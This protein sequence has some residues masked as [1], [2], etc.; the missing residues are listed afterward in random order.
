MVKMLNDGDCQRSAMALIMQPS[1]KFLSAAHHT[2]HLILAAN[3]CNG[4][5]GGGGGSGN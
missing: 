5:G 3:G 2:G 4:G 1:F